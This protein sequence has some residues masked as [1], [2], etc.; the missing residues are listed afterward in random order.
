MGIIFQ[1]VWRIGRVTLNGGRRFDYF[2]TGIPVQTAPAGRFV[3]ARSFP[4]Q[5]NVPNW[6]DI[7]PRIGGVWDV[8]GTG[9]TAVKASVSRYLAAQTAAFAQSVNPMT[10]LATDTRTWTDPN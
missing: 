8:F 2:N 5:E 9:K 1:D 10:A 3:P 7:S 6:K 4:A